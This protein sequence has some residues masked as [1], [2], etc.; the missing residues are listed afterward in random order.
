MGAVTQIGP[1]VSESQLAGNR[2]YVRLAGEEGCEV[3]GGQR[4]DPFF[5]AN[6]PEELAEARQL[7]Q[8]ESSTP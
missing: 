7:I 5:N 4:L 8:T 2:D 3:I 6:T 1:V